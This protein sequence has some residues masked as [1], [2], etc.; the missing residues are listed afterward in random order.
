MTSGQKIER[1]VMIV[2]LTRIIA[3]IVAIA[4][5]CLAFY[6]YFTKEPVE[7][8]EPTTEVF[9]TTT[10]E[11]ISLIAT[12]EGNTTEKA[13]TKEGTPTRTIAPTT[14]KPIITTTT[15]KPTT[16]TKKQTTTIKRRATQ[17]DADRY[18][19]MAIEY[20][21]K[22][23]LTYDNGTPITSPYADGRVST[24]GPVFN[25]SEEGDYQR[26][27]EWRFK[28]AEE[29]YKGLD[30]YALT[31]YFYVHCKFRNDDYQIEI[32]RYYYPLGA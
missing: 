2:I 11:P 23:G 26:S 10:A 12:T 7:P 13:T 24:V 30:D 3:P 9:T 27:I 1:N 4:G 5:T 31:N 32:G 21:K 14:K 22:V 18:T 8:P 25:L 17:T 15:K 16:T 29:A 28:Q 6:V 19:Q 20:G